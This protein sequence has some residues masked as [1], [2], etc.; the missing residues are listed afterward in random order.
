[1]HNVCPHRGAPVCTGRLRPRIEDGDGF[2]FWYSPQNEVLKCPW[3]QWEF[4]LRTGRALHG[5]LI[6]PTYSIEV[7]GNQ[8]ILCY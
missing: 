8:L 5:D 3:H 6:I 4:D 7:E 1:M 2:E